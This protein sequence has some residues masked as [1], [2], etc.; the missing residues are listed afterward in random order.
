MLEDFGKKNFLYHFHNMAYSMI[1]KCCLCGGL[2]CPQDSLKE[3]ALGVQQLLR[4]AEASS[5]YKAEEMH[6][7][8]VAN[9]VPQK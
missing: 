3:K 5:D 7:K 9:Q 1:G 8:K 2:K 4:K 6:L